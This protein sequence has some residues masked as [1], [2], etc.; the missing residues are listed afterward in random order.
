MLDQLYNRVICA[1]FPT[2]TSAEEF[3]TYLGLHFM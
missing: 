1:A 3:Y 2:L